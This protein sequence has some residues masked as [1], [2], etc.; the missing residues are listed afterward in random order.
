MHRKLISIL[1]EVAVE[2]LFGFA[3]NF[4]NIISWTDF[5][6]SWVEL[7]QTDRQCR[8]SS[9]LVEEREEAEVSNKAIIQGDQLLPIVRRGAFKLQWCSQCIFFDAEAEAR[10]WTL[11]MGRGE[12][13]AAT[14]RPSRQGIRRLRPEKN[15]NTRKTSLRGSHRQQT[16]SHRIMT[17][18]KTSGSVCFVLYHIIDYGRGQVQ[19]P[20]A[21]PVEAEAR[22]RRK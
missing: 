6:T 17:P 18:I 22:L 19:L 2:V 4:C 7:S 11:G 15:R 3:F 13:E 20:G 1:R 12:T 5:L 10:Q 8:A 21:M 16:Y 14:P 9:I